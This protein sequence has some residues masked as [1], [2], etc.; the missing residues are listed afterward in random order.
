MNTYSEALDTIRAMAAGIYATAKTEEEVCT[1]E[2]DLYA[3]I[4]TIAEE[5]LVYLEE[6]AR[7]RP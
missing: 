6:T 5:R 1:L 7:F 3:M 2:Q 4:R